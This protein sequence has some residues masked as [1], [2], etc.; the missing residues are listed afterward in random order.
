MNLLS[1][2]NKCIQTLLYQI[3]SKKMTFKT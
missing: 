2:D 3:E 1:L